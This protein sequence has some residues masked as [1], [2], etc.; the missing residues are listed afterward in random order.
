LS[1]FSARAASGSAVSVTMPP[2]EPAFGPA[3]TLASTGV[4]TTDAERAAD[5][6]TTWATNAIT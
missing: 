4:R 6:S 5:H 1:T 3:A 2:S